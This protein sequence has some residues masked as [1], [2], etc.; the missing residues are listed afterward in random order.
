[1]VLAVQLSLPSNVGRS[2]VVREGGLED[3]SIVD[4]DLAK[5]LSHSIRGFCP[6]LLLSTRVSPCD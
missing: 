3:E 1:M 6:G 5:H 4:P 2:R